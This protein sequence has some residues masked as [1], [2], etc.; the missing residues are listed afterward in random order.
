MIRIALQSPLDRV[1]YIDRDFQGQGVGSALFA[2]VVEWFLARG[3]R[4]VLLWVVRENRAAD[5]YRILGG[6]ISGAHTV[7]IGGEPIAGL[8]FEW[9]D[10]GQLLKRLQE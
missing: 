3:F 4:S 8:R 2:A 7:T 6:V 5:W 1:L 10:I 9:E